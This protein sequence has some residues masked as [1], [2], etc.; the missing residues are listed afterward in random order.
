M[1]VAGCGG[2]PATGAGLD[3]AATEA[4][5]AAPGFDAGA[6]STTGVPGTGGAG[7][8]LV[9]VDAFGD[10]EDAGGVVDTGP[11][12]GGGGGNSSS[13]ILIYGVTTSS[14]R[15]DSIPAAAKALSQAMAKAGLTAELVGV[16]NDTNKV[17]QS[18]FTAEALAQY[19]A[20]VLLAIGGEP[21][22]NPADT[23]IQNL[24]DYVRGGGAL[25]GVETAS[26]CYSDVISGPMTGHPT[27]P[28]LHGLIGGTFAGHAD[29]GPA[30]CTKVG[31]HPSV[32]RLAPSF[33]LVDEIYTFVD[34]RM[35]NQ[36]VLNCVSGSLPNMVRPIS[37][38]REEG[39]G[40]VFYTGLGHLASAWMG[41]MDSSAESRLVE[42]HF[43]PGLLWSMKRTP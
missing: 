28:V 33:R 10:A 30:V 19:G 18:K 24:V 14:F 20:I 23:E 37:W 34:F 3:A 40:R 35:D 5:V 36:V 4:P 16:S 1:I 6:E 13:K 39:A 21:F 22:G 12:G 25:V 2:T 38:Y 42:D 41:P 27:S 32:A 43:L 9:A 15:H 8:G 29:L 7:P 26:A 11:S 31:S 17:D